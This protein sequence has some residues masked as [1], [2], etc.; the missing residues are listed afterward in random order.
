MLGFL[1]II[2]GL[3]MLVAASVDFFY[4]EKN[5]FTS[6]FDFN[7]LLQ[8]NK[9]NGFVALIE[10][11]AITIFFGVIF[12]LIG[13][14]SSKQLGLRE[15]YSIVSLVWIFFSIFGMLPFLFSGAVDNVTDAFFESMSG[16]TTT[17][18]SFFVNVECF[19]HS[20]LL[21]RSLTEW[22]GGMGIVVLSL[23]ILPFL[24]VSMQLFTAESTGVTYDKLAPRIK[25]TARRLW[26]MYAVLTLILAA[27]L[28]FEGMGIF[29]AVNHALTT[30]A[31]GGYSTKDASL[32]H[33]NSQLI[34]YTII[35]FM[36]LTGINYT[37]MYFALVQHKFSKLFK[38]EE[39]KTFFWVIIVF[40]IIILVV[41]SLTIREIHS[42][43]DFEQ[44]FRESLFQTVS[45]LSTT[46]FYVSD[47][48]IWS[49]FVL[50]LLV[51]LMCSGACAGST[52]GGMKMIRVVIMFKNCRYELRRLLHPNAILP[53][54]INNKTLQNSV[55]ANVYAFMT[56][57]VVLFIAGFLALLMAQMPVKEAFI[58]SISC[59]SNSCSTIIGGTYST[60]APAAKWI[61]SALMLVGRLEI[62]TVVLLFSK[63]L[64][65]K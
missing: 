59:I 45:V 53:I 14:R 20:L 44:N 2:E 9:N 7:L 33:W 13:F 38:D 26:G 34:H 46:G 62:F 56:L 63:E 22:L 24:G 40:T 51:L 29:D 52:T 25:D 30:I 27:L 55:T 58:T 1:I 50:I 65:K 6:G 19:P 4:A 43:Y 28:Y 57:F 32:A 60:A 39:F 42:I 12:Y 16:F 8:I 49:P 35:L 10:S 23:A 54:R 11:G 15:G 31:S 47:Y 5:I 3:L 18:S 41:N 64:W 17:G 21:W 48:K 37:L 61:M 36:F